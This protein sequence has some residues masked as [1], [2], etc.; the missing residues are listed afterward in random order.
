MTRVL[1]VL[2]HSLPLHSGYTFRTRAILKAQQGHGLDLPIRIG[3][4]SGPVV[5]GVIGRQRILF[6]LW[7]DT[8]NT[9]SRI[10]SAA[11]PGK[12]WI[13][14][15]VYEEVR[16]FFDLTVRPAIELKG[17]KHTVQPFEVHAE[18]K[19]PMVDLP[20]FVGRETEWR[21]IQA[22]LREAV[23]QKTLKALFVRGAAGCLP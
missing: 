15:P 23:Q 16:R 1:H 21:L 17:K 6:D 4:A 2:D 13:S 22:T 8:V 19:V 5:G 14:Q 9:A 18:R 20:P 12:V 7:G 10:Q 11:A 3:L